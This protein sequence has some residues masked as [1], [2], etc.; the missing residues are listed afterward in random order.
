MAPVWTR[1]G[2][3]AMWNDAERG[4]HIV[5]AFLPPDSAGY[6]IDETR[7][8]LGMRGTRSDDVLL[9]G[10]FVPDKYIA[11]IV[12]AGTGDEFVLAAFA[13]ALLGFSHGGRR[14][15]LTTASPADE[16]KFTSPRVVPAPP[17]SIWPGGGRG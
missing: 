8:T 13:W 10:A 4:P 3:H 17:P 6:R 5:H 1:Y 15:G 14:D 2:L 7:D 12:P 11:R 9:E 16:S